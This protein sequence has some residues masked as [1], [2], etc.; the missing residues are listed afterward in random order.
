[1]RYLFWTLIGILLLAQLIAYV[2]WRIAFRSPNRRQNDDY[3]LAD[4]EQFRP[5]QKTITGM[6]DRLNAIPFERVWI[7]SF[8]GLE[9]SGR[10]YHHADGA[11][12]A[13]CC[14][15]YRGTPS[16]DF[17]GGAILYR[18]LGFNLLLI[19]QRAHLKSK[20]N[21]ITLGIKER[22]DCLAWIDYGIRRF[23]EDTQIVLSGIS[24]GAA[25]VLLVSGMQPPKNVK[26]IIADAPYTSPK[27]I[28]Q[29]ILK[30]LKLPVRL[31]YPF[32]RLGTWLYSGVDLSD[33]SAD[34]LC[35]VK[36]SPVPILLIH[37]EA[38][39]FVPCEMSR[40]IA[41]AAP[42]R[43]T[44]ETFPNAGHGL[45]F[46]SDQPRYEAITKAFLTR[47]LKAPDEQESAAILQT[48]E[49]GRREASANL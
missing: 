21:A 5:L 48:E 2:L 26:G 45:S 46:L 36:R 12:L 27:A 15:G 4:T 9:L 19:E 44:L 34:V 23:G 39:R 38:D 47:V 8:D 3:H 20:G 29:S 30:G 11:P 49:S 43:V 24:M 33:S 32:L 28:L 31:V 17:S 6:I 10:Y 7:R 14:H 40:A 22:R 37:G 41:A 35:A 1:M 42:D 18:E 16:R 25:T 13:I